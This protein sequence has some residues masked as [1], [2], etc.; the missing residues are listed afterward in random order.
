MAGRRCKLLLFF[1]AFFYGCA[2]LDRVS[3]FENRTWDKTWD[4]GPVLYN[5]EGMPFELYWNRFHNDDCS[6]YLSPRPE[7][8]HNIAL[9][10]SYLP[11]MVPNV[12]SLT[13]W[14]IE[15]DNDSLTFEAVVTCDKHQCAF[16][17]SKVIFSINDKYLT[18]SNIFCSKISADTMPYKTYLFVP[19]NYGVSEFNMYRYD[20]STIKLI[21]ETLHVVFQLPIS[22]HKADD[23]KIDFGPAITDSNK[24]GIKELILYRNSRY[25][26]DP[27]FFMRAMNH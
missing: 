26:Y 22:K 19:G 2:S 15:A 21:D 13:Y 24:S 9:S 4:K 8:G 20:G 27:A 14:L 11:I 12:F 17:F 25:L 1:L 23:I 3:Y 10:F 7:Y 5:Y 18:P 6:I 16:D